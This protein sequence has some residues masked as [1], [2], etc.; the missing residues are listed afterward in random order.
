MVIKLKSASTPQHV[1]MLLSLFY[2][3][4]REPDIYKLDFPKGGQTILGAEWSPHIV[5][6][7]EITKQFCINIRR[8]IIV[9]ISVDPHVLPHKQTRNNDWYYSDS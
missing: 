1:N 4:R 6:N 7:S 9:D 8:D 5:V 2:P 3:E